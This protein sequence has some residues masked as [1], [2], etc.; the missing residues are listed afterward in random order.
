MVPNPPELR[1]VLG[2]SI[3]RYWAAHIW[4][5]PTSV[6]KTA[7]LPAALETSS[8]TYCGIMQPSWG[9]P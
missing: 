2:L 1:K 3:W 6:T 7:S 9:L 4:C 5:W 8:M